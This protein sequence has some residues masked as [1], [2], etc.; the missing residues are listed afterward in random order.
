MVFVCDDCGCCEGQLHEPFCTRENC[1]F[2]GG[3]LV[4]CSCI[5]TVLALTP[6][7]IEVLQAFEDDACDPLKGIVRRWERALSR[8]GRIPFQYRAEP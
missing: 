8:K 5:R 1:P 6:E 7:E 3:Q 2:C 4:S